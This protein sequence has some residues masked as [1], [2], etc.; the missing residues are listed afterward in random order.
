MLPLVLF[1]LAVSPSYAY[2]ISGR[3][4]QESMSWVVD[5]SGRVIVAALVVLFS[6]FLRQVSGVWLTK[7]EQLANP[8]FTTVQAIVKMFSIGIFVWLFTH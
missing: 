8:Y 2:F 1:A 7:E 3:T 5:L 4:P 6:S